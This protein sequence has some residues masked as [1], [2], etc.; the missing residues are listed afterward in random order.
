MQDLASRALVDEDTADRRLA[1]QLLPQAVDDFVQ[2]SQQVNASG[3]EAQADFVFGRDILDRVRAAQEEEGAAAQAELDVLLESR[4][5][6]EQAVDLLAQPDLDA[7]ALAAAIAALPDGFGARDEVLALARDV[8]EIQDA[9]FEQSERISAALALLAPED[10]GLDAPSSGNVTPFSAAVPPAFTANEAGGSATAAPT[11]TPG[12]G[13]TQVSQEADTQQ[14]LYQVAKRLDV[15]AKQDA[16]YYA[17]Q[18]RRDDRSDS[19][20]GRIANQR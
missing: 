4:D 6:L 5:L 1:R 7:G 17:A 19:K 3:P 9:I 20:L 10:V 18:K 15:I 8:L 14:G 2:R 12:G 11:A 16:D 13:S